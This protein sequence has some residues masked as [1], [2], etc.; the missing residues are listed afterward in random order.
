MS[1]KYDV[2]IQPFEYPKD[3]IYTRNCIFNESKEMFRLFLLKMKKQ[4]LVD[5]IMFSEFLRVREQLFQNLF[6]G[7]MRT[8]SRTIK[9][10]M[11]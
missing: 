8:K 1:K 2:L 10:F 9:A 5:F 7:Q 3:R 11:T 6:V 4:E